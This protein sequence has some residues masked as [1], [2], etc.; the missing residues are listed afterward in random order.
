MTVYAY[1]RVSTK[2]QTVENQELQ[3]TNAGFKIDRWIEEEGVSGSI[4][5][6]ERPEFSALMKRLVKGDT[7][8]VIHVDRLGRNT[9]DILHTARK[10]KEAGVHLRVMALDGTDLTSSTGKLLLT[11]MAALAEMERDRCIERTNSGLARAKADGRVFGRHLKIFP[12]VLEN[13]LIDKANGASYTQLVETYN[14]SRTTLCRTVNEWGD[15][16]EEYKKVYSKQQVQ[17]AEKEGGV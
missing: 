8:V 2:D 3:I 12:D 6:L 13:I 17:K 4:R 14:I 7:V 1:L 16:L 15:K 5:A 11:M 10:F 9:E